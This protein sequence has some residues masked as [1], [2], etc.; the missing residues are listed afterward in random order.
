MGKVVAI[1]CVSLGS[2]KNLSEA[3]LGFSIDM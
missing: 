2:E 1:M 3:S